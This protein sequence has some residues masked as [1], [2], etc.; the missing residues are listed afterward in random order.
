MIIKK[1]R[2]LLETTISIE[3]AEPSIIKNEPI[4]SEQV[5]IEP[6]E[7]PVE[8]NVCDLSLKKS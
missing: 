8:I 6:K 7:E 2:F 3:L 1:K 5:V 4:E